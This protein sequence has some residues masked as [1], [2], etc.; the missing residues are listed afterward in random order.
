MKNESGELALEVINIRDNMVF[1]SQGPIADRTKEHLS[2]V[3]RGV[4]MLRQLLKQQMA[5]VDD[6]GEPMNVFRDTEKYQYI[7]LPTLVRYNARG[8]AADGSY[9]KG[10]VTAP[11]ITRYSPSWDCIEDLYAAAAKADGLTV[12]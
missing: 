5:I 10:A 8:R 11:I 7:S 6:G 4:I 2:E 12:N 9:L 1:E 3:N